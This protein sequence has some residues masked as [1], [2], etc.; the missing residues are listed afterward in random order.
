M[1]LRAGVLQKGC[2]VPSVRGLEVV[3]LRTVL[4]AVF[5]PCGG[6][7]SEFRVNFMLT[8]RGM[9]GLW[10]QHACPS[11]SRAMSSMSGSP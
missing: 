10:S 5:V 7:C 9:C 3:S 4:A 6:H 11:A 1:N 8:C 2:V